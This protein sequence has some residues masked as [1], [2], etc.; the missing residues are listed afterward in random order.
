MT[1]FKLNLD[2]E[3]LVIARDLKHLTAKLTSLTSSLDLLF[4]IK[5]K[6]ESAKRQL[7]M[8]KELMR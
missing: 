6:T 3:K 2:Q 1:D 5:R 4:D 8:A 7:R